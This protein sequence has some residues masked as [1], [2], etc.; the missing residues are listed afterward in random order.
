MYDMY[1]SLKT[2]IPK[3]NLSIITYTITD[4]LVRTNLCFKLNPNWYL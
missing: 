2:N 1:P 4:V 3:S